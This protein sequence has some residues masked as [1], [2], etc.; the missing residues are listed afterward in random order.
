MWNDVMIQSLATARAEE[1]LRQAEQRRLARLAHHARR[2]AAEAGRH[3]AEPAVRPT[4]AAAA[5]TPAAQGC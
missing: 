1:L 3:R 5:T 4:A 2:R